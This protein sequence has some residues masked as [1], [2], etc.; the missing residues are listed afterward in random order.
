MTPVGEATI[1]IEEEADVILAGRQVKA[2]LSELDFEA[3]A[4]EEIALVVHELASNIVKHAGE[5][6]IALVPRSAN[7]R[8]GFEVRARDS[9]PGIAD[10]DQAVVDGYS[11]TGT[12]G[13]GLGAVHRLMD[14]VVINSAPGSDVGVQI[15]ATRWQDP[16]RS[17]QQVP[18]LAIGAAT[19][20][21]PG[22]TQNGDA[23]LIEHGAGQSLVGI[24]DGLG[25]GREAHRASSEAQQHVRSHSSQPLSDLFAGV[26]RV[27]RGNRG[28]VMLLARFNWDAAEVTL[29]SVGNITLRV[30]HST[31]SRH[32]VSKRG[33]LGANAP[34]PKIAAW[35]WEPSSVMVLHSDGLTSRWSCDDVSLRDGRPV[36][37]TA[38]ALLRSLSSAD[39]DATVLVIRGTDR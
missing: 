36:T 9:G 17:N 5:G 28:V 24:I 16:S 26:G 8:T 11:T 12:L 19:R 13:G 38:N 32:L 34:S 22:R 2:A 35:E 25:H 15:V 29:G 31:E 1:A 7:G 4:I 6:S 3:S 20:P 14:D 10:V 18:P 37:V 30:C 21:K 33:V 39:D 23:F 27:C